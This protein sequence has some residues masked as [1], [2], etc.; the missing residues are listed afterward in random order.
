ML[1]PQQRSLLAALILLL[2]V[3]LLSLIPAVYHG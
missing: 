1:L 3:S 2:L